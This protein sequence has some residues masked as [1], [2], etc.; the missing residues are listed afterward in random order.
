MYRLQKCPKW[1]GT[2]Q[3]AELLGVVHSFQVVA[4]MRWDR[5]YLGS[6]SSVA[7]AQ[8]TS[9]RASTELHVQQRMLCRFFWFRS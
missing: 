1:I 3:Q 6:D 7:R 4:F 9:L 8:A 2:L 5:A